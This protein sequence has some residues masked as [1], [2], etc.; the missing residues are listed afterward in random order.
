[1][2]TRSAKDGFCS[3]RPD[4]RRFVALHWDALVNDMQGLRRDNFHLGL[5]IAAEILF[6]ARREP[7]Y[8]NETRLEIGECFIGQEKLA[9]KFRVKRNRIRTVLES[10]QRIGFISK[11]SSP[12]GTVIKIP[13]YRRYVKMGKTVASGTHGIHAQ[14]TPQH[15]QQF[16]N[17]SPPIIDKQ[18][19]IGTT[20]ECDVDDEVLEML[21]KKAAK[22]HMTRDGIRRLFKSC[23]ED[24]KMVLGWITWGLEQKGAQNPAGL[25]L[26]QAAT[27]DSPIL[28]KKQQAGVEKTLY[29]HGYKYAKRVH[30]VLKSRNP[31]VPEDVCQRIPQSELGH[32]RPWT[33]GEANRVIMAIETDIYDLQTGEKSSRFQD[34]SG[35]DSVGNILQSNP[36]VRAGMGLSQGGNN[37][38]NQE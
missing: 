20:T 16:A 35:P 28:T 23:K 24:L 15:H 18:E 34:K 1:M 19:E 13:S 26:S 17:A 2:G 14:S 32:K 38:N 29:E 11:Q 5:I 12:Q 3:I 21:T 25:I 27:G 6:R 30:A 10:L 36:I 37:V 4:E 7:G 31:C 8:V 33:Q 22:L 9:S